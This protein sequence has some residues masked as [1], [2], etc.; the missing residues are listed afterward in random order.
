MEFGYEI[1]ADHILHDPEK[2]DITSLCVCMCL[3][4]HSSLR[5]WHM[6]QKVQINTSLLGVGEEEALT[7]A[8]ECRCES[9]TTLI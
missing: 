6:G 1:R 2:G 3:K 7:M 9:E 8:D 4:E 5:K